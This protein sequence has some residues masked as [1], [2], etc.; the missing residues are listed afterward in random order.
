MFA[1]K[2]FLIFTE[3][4]APL[5][6]AAYCDSSEW[7]YLS[8]NLIESNSKNWKSFILPKICFYLF[9]R[10]ISN[11][12]RY[13]YEKIKRVNVSQKILSLSLWFQIQFLFCAKN[14]E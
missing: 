8:L 5:R 10:K 11:A 1:L 3:Q 13:L 6:F 7:S 9:N 14:V 4:N 2:K 12:M